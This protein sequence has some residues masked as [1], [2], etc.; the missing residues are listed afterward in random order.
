[1]LEARDRIG[2]R[3]HTLRDPEWP[4]PVELGAEFVHGENPLIVSMARAAGL[5]I[6]LLP[7]RHDRARRGRIEPLGDFW[8]TMTSL[9]RRLR[10]FARRRD[11]TAE[12]FLRRG[13]LTSLER[14]QFRDY[15]EGYDAA[16]LERVSG[17]WLAG[18]PDGESSEDRRQFRLREGYGPLLSWL[19]S[20]LDPELTALRLDR[21]AVRLDWSEGDVTVQCRNAL[22][23]EF[24]PFRARAAIVALPLA[25]LKAGT[26]RIDPSPRDHARALARLFG[27]QAFRIVFRFREDFWN[28][29]GPLSFLHVEGAEVPVFWTAVPA[30]VPVITGWAGGA[31]AER[32]LAEPPPRRVAAA[33]ESLASGLGFSRRRLEEKLEGHRTHDWQADPHSRAAYTYVGVGG[34]KAP[35]ALGRPVKDTLFFAGEATDA[36]ETGT[37]GAALASGRRAAQEVLRA[38][39]GA[40]R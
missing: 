32:L 13:G 40:P 9:R 2:G 29:P 16:H 3:V 8:K 4:V 35:E 25:V 5:A 10:R 15:A 11:V 37:V 34:E 39:R 12:A 33:L 17:R 36:D 23:T 38:H 27:G 1:M 19:R 30:R 7:D 31:R 26:L 14:R 24:G 28:R 18:D 20:G 22:G 6:D 21:E